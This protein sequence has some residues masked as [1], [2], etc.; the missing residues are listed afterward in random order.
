MKGASGLE[1]VG[2]ATSAIALNYQLY[3]IICY[4]V[5]MYASKIFMYVMQNNLKLGI[6]TYNK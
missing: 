3:Q 5:F 2:D 1:H 6:S 4:F